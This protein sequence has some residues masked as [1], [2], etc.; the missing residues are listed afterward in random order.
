[1]KCAS[2]SLSS[3]IIYLALPS[4]ILAQPNMRGTIAGSVSGT[5]TG[6]DGQPLL[7]VI[8]AL[9]PASGR[10]QSS[11]NGAFT[12]SSLAPGRYN[13]CAAVKTPGY[14]DPC[15]WEPVLPTVQ[16][17]A[18]QATTGYRLVAKKGARFRSA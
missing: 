14:L 8:T 18:R 3:L 17:V 9:G 1:M 15:A 13:L 11:A 6:S 10:A 7:A 2:I 12:L 5:V 4:A 16:V